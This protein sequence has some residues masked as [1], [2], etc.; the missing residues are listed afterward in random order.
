MRMSS[1]R[2]QHG[3]D[4]RPEPEGAGWSGGAILKEKG[5]QKVQG[6]PGK[7]TERTERL[8]DSFESNGKSLNRYKQTSDPTQT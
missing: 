1:L 6:R 5:S 2:T 4:L 7:E 8:W 3:G